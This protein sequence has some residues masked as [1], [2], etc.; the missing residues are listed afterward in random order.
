[1]EDV[2][3][4]GEEGAG[5]PAAREKSVLLDMDDEDVEEGAA[6]D[7]IGAGGSL[8]VD[9]I[10]GK[11]GDEPNNGIEMLPRTASASQ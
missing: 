6:E 4:G 1:M 2:K 5:N 10:Q 11:G 7:A 3:A 8:Q 9:G